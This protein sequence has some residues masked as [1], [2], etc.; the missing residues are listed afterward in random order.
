MREKRNVLFCEDQSLT[1]QSYRKSSDL[2][3]LIKKYKKTGVMPDLLQKKGQYGD[4]SNVPTLEAAFKAVNHAKML[5]QELP[6]EVR[7]LMD[8]D[9]SKMEL[10]LSDEV[11][12]EIAEKYGLLDKNSQSSEEKSTPKEG[13][14]SS[15]EIQN[16][17]DSKSTEGVKNASSSN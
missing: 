17:S 1:D 9:P 8:N 13:L 11:N 7:K 12:H 3:V 2:N 6:A 4:F 14:N 5:F 10:W 15:K 16:E